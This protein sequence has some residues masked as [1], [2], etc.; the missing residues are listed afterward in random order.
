MQVCDVRGNKREENKERKLMYGTIEGG[1]S[2]EGNGKEM[3][4]RS[5]KEKG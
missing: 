5:R 4:R 3:E 2:N 1:T